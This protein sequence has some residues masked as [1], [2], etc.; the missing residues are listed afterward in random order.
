MTKPESD[1]NGSFGLLA[2]GT[3]GCWSVDLDESQDGREWSLQLDGP[4]LY[5]AFPIHDLTVIQSA[6][7]Y[8]RGGRHRADALSLG[9]FESAGVSL[10]RDD[11]FP[12]RC[13]LIVGPRTRATMRFALS[14]ED[15]TMLA[16]ALEQVQQDLPDEQMR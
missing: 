3:A 16:E 5:L 13:F 10:H 12:D 15:A 8:L 11:E 9:Q 7:E 6:I 4:L 1:A 14:A 2:N